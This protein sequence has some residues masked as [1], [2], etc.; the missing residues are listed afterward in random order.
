M[1]FPSDLSIYEL[2]VSESI[3]EQV[4]SYITVWV[5]SSY[6]NVLKNKAGF[7]HITEVTDDTQMTFP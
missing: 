7:L 4:T 6:L 3:I 2:D 5:F 1:N